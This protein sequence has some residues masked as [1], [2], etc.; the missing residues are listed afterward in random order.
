MADERIE[1]EKALGHAQINQADAAAGRE[2][3]V[4]VRGVSRKPSTTG[5]SDVGS[6]ACTS[7][8]GEYLLGD[9]AT[10]VSVDHVIQRQDEK[11]ILALVKDALSASQEEVPEKVVHTVKKEK[12]EQPQLEV[13][14]TKQDSSDT[15][16]P[17]GES[18]R[19]QNE[20]SVAAPSSPES[21]K[22]SADIINVNM[23]TPVRVVR[24]THE[25]ETNDK[26]G[27]TEVRPRECTPPKVASTPVNK[28]NTVQEV[29]Q[30]LEVVH[31]YID[32]QGV[33][34]V[35]SEK[36]DTTDP[37]VEDE[38]VSDTSSTPY[39]SF[40]IKSEEVIKTHEDISKG[41]VSLDR[42]GTNSP[43][44]ETPLQG[45]RDTIMALYAPTPT[46]DAGDAVENLD[47]ND[48]E[49]PTDASL[50]DGEAKTESAP[51]NGVLCISRNDEE[52]STARKEVE[53]MATNFEPKDDQAQTD[54][55]EEEMEKKNLKPKDER[56]QMDPKHVEMAEKNLL[57]PET[58]EPQIINVPFEPETAKLVNETLEAQADTT[59]VDKESSVEGS[60][61]DHPPSEA[62]IT[63]E[64]APF[65]MGDHVYQWCSF[66]LVP[67][68]FQH[69]GI[70]LEVRPEAEGDGWILKIADYVRYA[71]KEED[72]D[73]KGV[74][75]S[76]PSGKKPLTPQKEQGGATNS[77]CLRV[78]ESSSKEWHKVKYGAKFWE[79][80]T[81][82]SGTCTAA[83]CEPPGMV[84][85]RMQFLLDHPE[86]LPSYDLMNSN[87]ECVAVWCK[88]GTW[89]TLQAASWLAITAAGQAK[90]AMTVA[91]VA[92]STQVTV[93]AS[94]LWGT[95]GY[96][97]QASFLSMH[98]F[99]VPLI[100]A[101]GVVTAG[102][103]A[104]SLMRCKRRWREQTEEM[105]QA[106]WEDA[107]ENPGVFVECITRWSSLH[108]P[109]VTGAA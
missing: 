37:S 6:S 32:A 98:P 30:A 77:G 54:P 94:G 79:R 93:P 24:S 23:S 34:V 87:C 12:M 39:F 69:H 100:A 78:Y 65:A 4:P 26:E 55:K 15:P 45:Y 22:A 43:V 19:D 50:T 7:L 35:D 36:E 40:P 3:H 42:Q 29:H 11:S 47:G 62:V 74:A 101:Y 41:M 107:V 63:A 28:T 108:E 106:F 73:Q 48:S 102:V 38:L 86:T 104:V 46:K 70:V 9:T 13:G 66:A 88:T 96:T 18:K 71:G 20:T 89:G 91:G 61:Q 103:P 1:A 21:Q 76:S 59:P 58:V 97:T 85:A 83:K 33:V 92:A 25:E 49:E 109:A 75:V 2:S 8:I 105:N 56:A 80:H 16:L 14:E 53:T 5:I 67:S 51:V 95:I 68:V 31:A 99:A 17:C 52:V 60:G 57:E 64:E 10:D 44:L 90:S 27:E 72:K 84:R 82:R 81:A